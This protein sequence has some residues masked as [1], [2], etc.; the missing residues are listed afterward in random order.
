M[1][2]DLSPILSGE[3]DRLPFSFTFPLQVEDE[4]A[5]VEFEDCAVSGL[6]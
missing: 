3:T 2:L 4:F 5:D 1:L 6:W